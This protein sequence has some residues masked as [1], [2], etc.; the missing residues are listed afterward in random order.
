[1][2]EGFL[3]IQASEQAAFREFLD[4]RGSKHAQGIE[5][6][7]ARLAPTDEQRDSSEL[8]ADDDFN[9]EAAHL[10]L[11]ER[12]LRDAAE[13]LEAKHLAAAKARMEFE[14]KARL[15][16]EG[17]TDDERVSSRIGSDSDVVP[18]IEEENRYRNEAE[19]LRKAA[20]ELARR[21]QAV[22][23]V[24]TADCNDVDPAIEQKQTGMPEL[25]VLSKKSAS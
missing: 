9:T 14:E 2:K 22:E 15:R 23:A 16:A 21:R 19:T 25:E 4:E 3:G 5:T 6:A 13:G 10:L 12:T 20:G 1:M 7:T 24:R 18:S 11:Q 17:R 8:H